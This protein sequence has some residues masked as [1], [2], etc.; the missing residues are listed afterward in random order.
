MMSNELLKQKILDEAIR[1]K[2]NER[3]LFSAKEY[4]KKLKEEQKKYN[5]KKQSVS[6][7]SNKDIP[8]QIPK[9]WVWEK[10]G[11][12]EEI[13]LGFTYKPE[14]ADKG[15]IFLSVKDI[16]SGKIDFSRV[17]HV[18]Q[19][20]YDKA[21]YGCKPKKGD[22]LFGRIGTI[23]V[24]Y[25]VDTDDKMCIFVSLGFFRDYT[26]LINKKYICYWMNSNLFKNQV[27]QNVKGAAQINLNTNWLKEFLIPFPPLEEQEEIVKKIEE[28]FEL[29]DKKEKNDK[30]KEK[31]KTLLKEKI[32]DRAIHGELIENDL[33][34]QAINVE[35][36]KADIP[37]DVPSNWKWCS[38]KNIGDSG[39]GLTYKPSNI[40][41]KGMIV[42]RSSNIQEG[43]LDLKDI[44]RV[45]CKV[46]DNIIARENDI[47]IC[48]R[49]GSKR[50]IGKSCLL[51]NL[52]EKMTYGAFMTIFR[53]PYYRYVYWFMQSK[54][55]Y[56]QLHENT[57]TMTINQITQKKL[58]SL[59]VPIPPLEQQ[60]K[61]VEKIEECFKLI[62][63]L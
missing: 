60:K 52:N 18:S 19:E 13:N 37:F 22:I 39:V 56:N 1:G 8:F 42:L 49:N 57:N 44:V 28:L 10:I 4:L 47:L 61:I 20:V 46:K 35:E 6:I 63:Q 54:H 26:E 15:V 5:Y 51:K 38:Y 16:S 62:E 29:I 9:N 59:L 7:I 31:L 50:L 24:P 33:S 27:K 34:L 25:I 3:T 23:G 41:N 14:Y 11:N 43:K 30:E 58:G 12:L 17:Q 55:Y 36:V 53:T 45:D 48:A 21:A 40:N 32:L 2:L